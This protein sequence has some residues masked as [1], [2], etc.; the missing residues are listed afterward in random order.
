LIECSA[1]QMRQLVDRALDGVETEQIPNQ[2]SLHQAAAVALHE[3]DKEASGAS[4][5]TAQLLR[6]AERQQLKFRE[7]L[8]S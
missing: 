8:R 5:F 1:K 3:L 4:A 2:I 6:E 7:L